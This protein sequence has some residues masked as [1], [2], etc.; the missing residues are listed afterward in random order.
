MDLQLDGKRVLVTGRSSGIGAGIAKALAREGASVVIHSRDPARAGRVVQE[1]FSQGGRVF[2]ALGDLTT[3]A[4]AEYVAEQAVAG[5][6]AIDVLINNAGRYENRGWTD[7]T[8]DDSAELYRANVLSR[9]C[10]G[11]GDAARTG[12]LVLRVELDSK[13][14]RIP[15]K[16]WSVAAPTESC[17]IR[18]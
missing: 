18:N 8:P 4:G 6:G 17:R 14:M 9:P 12:Q 16:S 11:R 5:A 13:P 2:M 7:T 1:I 15:E 3:D 10:C